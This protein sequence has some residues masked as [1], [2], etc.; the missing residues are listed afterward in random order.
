MIIIP[1]GDDNPTEREPWVTYGLLL[2]N[3]FVF[4]LMSYP[5][6]EQ[7]LMSYE[8]FVNMLGVVPNNLRL[9]AL[10]THTFIHGGPLHLVG[11]MIFLWITGRHVEDRFGHVWFALF[12]VASG[13][14]AALIHVAMVIAGGGNGDLPTV[15]A[16]GAIAGVIAAYFL[17][18]PRHQIKMWYFFFRPGTF[19]IA[20][21][22]AVGFWFVEQLVLSLFGGG[23]LGAS[24]EGSGVAYWAH[25]GGFVFGLL[26]AYAVKKMSPRNELARS[27]ALYL[28]RDN[29]ERALA[30]YAQF[31]RRYPGE[32]LDPLVQFAAAE[33]CERNTAYD[34]ALDAYRRLA[35]KYPEDTNAAVA[36]F[37]AGLILGRYGGDAEGSKKM[38]LLALPRLTN[39]DQA[40]LCREQLGSFGVDVSQVRSAAPAVE[41]R[42]SNVAPGSLLTPLPGQD[43][44]PTIEIVD[45]PVTVDRTAISRDLGTAHFRE[46]RWNEAIE[47]FKRV[48]DA[49]PADTEARGY[50]G[51]AYYR[52]GML[53]D[54]I[55]ELEAVAGAQPQSTVAYHNLA[56]AYRAAGR[57]EDART[58]WE[59][60]L[61]IDGGFEPARK[62]L[63]S[64]GK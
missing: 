17:F 18:F 38:L 53:V 56:L 4:G 13:V 34:L 57:T 58:A 29:T 48:L 41:A 46:G 45:E 42:G 8:A 50:L 6:F 36:A 15:G 61:Q 12:Y 31:A 3:V 49:A 19:Y 20:A 28:A 52:N 39:R 60:A 14:V 2:S 43:L 51:V 5:F 62:G 22:W 35:D 47:E 63:G 64:L 21:S 16:S 30:N 9:H 59:T 1:L 55:R 7:T 44:P 24:A 32:S 27:V 40:A 11:N 54:A 25:V 33:E 10:I 37:K 26:S 23:G